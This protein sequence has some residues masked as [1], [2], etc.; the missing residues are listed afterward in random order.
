M[1]ETAEKVTILVKDFKIEAYRLDLGDCQQLLFTHRQIGEIIGKSKATARTFLKNNAVELPEPIKA[2][3][4]ARRGEIPLTL[5]EAAL[6]YWHYQDILGNSK[7][8]AILDAID[9]KP[10]SELEI[11]ASTNDDPTKEEAK[12]NYQQE[13]ALPDLSS[14]LKDIVEGIEVAASWVECLG[15]LNNKVI[16]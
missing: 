16:G 10:L 5:P 4:P 2:R 14:S 7:A 11:V 1:G 3:I 6:A 13:I 8:T 12:Q 9:N 15:S